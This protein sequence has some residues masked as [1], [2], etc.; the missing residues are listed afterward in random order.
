MKFLKEVR[1]F[2][3]QVRGG[4][5]RQKQDCDFQIRWL[6]LLAPKLSTFEECLK[7]IK[8]QPAPLESGLLLQSFESTIENMFDGK[9]VRREDP[10]YQILVNEAL[11]TVPRQLVFTA[12]RIVNEDG[13]PLK[14]LH[15][16]TDHYITQP[17]WMLML[18]D[19]VVW[20]EVP[21]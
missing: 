20:A 10:M 18:G 8:L 16:R 13:Y 14:G 3:E 1:Y 4:Y 7:Q 12:N 6:P 19:Y 11:L 5:F 2:W 21:S 17:F 15:I 9:S